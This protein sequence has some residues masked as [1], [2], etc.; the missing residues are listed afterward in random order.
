MVENYKVRATKELIK[1]K[2][3]TLK[4][5]ILKRTNFFEKAGNAQVVI[6][7]ERGSEIETGIKK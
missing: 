4:E 7:P 3:K 2:N 1:T 6:N 5:L